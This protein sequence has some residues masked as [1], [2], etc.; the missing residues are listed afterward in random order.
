MGPVSVWEDS[1]VLQTLLCHMPACTSVL[2]LGCQGT[3]AGGTRP[4][5][6]GGVTCLCSQCVDTGFPCRAMLG[7]L[8]QE[9]WF[10]LS[11]LPE[12]SQLPAVGEQV[13]RAAGWWTARQ[14]SRQASS[15]AGRQ[16]AAGSIFGG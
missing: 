5:P 1:G 13:R 9:T 10:L 15:C 4:P 6:C 3:F 12:I 14:Q 7:L 16:S 8:A 2:A 11:L